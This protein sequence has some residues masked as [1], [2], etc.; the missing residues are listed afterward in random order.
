MKPPCLVMVNLVLP[1]IRAIIARKL[2][3]EYGLSKAEAA[4]RVQLTRAAIT[5]YYKGIRGSRD[6]EMLENIEVSKRLLSEM[7]QNL[8]SG[9]H[10]ILPVYGK[11]CELCRFLRESGLLC[12]YCAE[13]LPGIDMSRCNFCKSVFC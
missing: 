7:A 10:N 13:L 6:L 3:D 12:E 9:D 5:Q 4:G 8:A 11:L 1:T 2:V